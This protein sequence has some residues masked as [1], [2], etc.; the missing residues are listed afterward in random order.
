[1]TDATIARVHAASSTRPL[2]AVRDL[3]A[4]TKPRV[5]ALVV[6]TAA[7]GAWLAPRAVPVAVVGAALAGT[8]L[9]VGAANA[10]NMWLERDVD[11][12]MRRTRDRPLPAGRMT[13]AA[14]L[15]FGVLLAVVATPL[16]LVA[17]LATCLL[18]LAALAVYVGAYTPLKRR[19]DLAILVGAVP[20]ALPPLMGWTL[21]SG[22]IQRGGLLLFALLFA[23]QLVHVAAIA[24]ARE[25]EYRRAGVLVVSVKRGRSVAR[26]VVRA[27]TPLLVATSLMPVLLGACGAVYAVV[28]AG[29]GV[30]MLWLAL[31]RDGGPRWARRTFLA[32]NAYLVVLVVALVVDRASALRAG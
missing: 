30:A 11:A 15:S 14:A 17:N 13:P 9:M 32:S 4:L 22:S 19:T 2:P 3:V 24:I 18:G 26:R 10:L 27:C 12:R 25:A 31:G 1:M 16:L 20:G 29:A 28:A 7:A 23:W 5:T 8:T 21:A 6:C